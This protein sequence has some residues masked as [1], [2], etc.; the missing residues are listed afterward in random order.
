VGEGYG[1]EAPREK[2]G[3]DVG[4]LEEA[5]PGGDLPKA[6]ES[7]E[8]EEGKKLVQ[9]VKGGAGQQKLSTLRG[10]ERHAGE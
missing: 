5:A 9:S 1:R 8:E 2:C 6:R 10:S 4:P 3:W 7:I